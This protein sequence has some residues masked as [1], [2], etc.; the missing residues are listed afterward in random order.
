MEQDRQEREGVG[1]STA[2]PQDVSGGKDLVVK[3]PNS[4]L[5]SADPGAAL[6]AQCEE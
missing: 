2:R 3:A 4:K 6:S 1:L 5:T